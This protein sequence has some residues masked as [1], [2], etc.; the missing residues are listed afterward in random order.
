MA[1]SLFDDLMALYA[2]SLGPPRRREL[3]SQLREPQSE[4]AQALAEIQRIARSEIDV[5]KVP[6]LEEIAA[7]E[8]RR[9]PKGGAEK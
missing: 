1:E 9:P 5:A 4:A 8:V 2:D 3:V 7:W 6:G